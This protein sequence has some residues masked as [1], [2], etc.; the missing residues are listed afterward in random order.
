M[1]DAYDQYADQADAG[2]DEDL[3]E[4]AVILESIKKAA[5]VVFPVIHSGEMPL[6]FNRRE[7][8][9][10]AAR[11]LCKK[12]RALARAL[13]FACEHLDDEQ[14]EELEKKLNA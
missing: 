10:S 6:D 1:R 2:G 9:N 7:K 4:T 3:I 13:E 14:L 12:G 8:V 11:L 5:D